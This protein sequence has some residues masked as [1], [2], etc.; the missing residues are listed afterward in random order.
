[1]I[2]LHVQIVN[3]I[4]E[5]VR[6]RNLE[7]LKRIIEN[8]SDLFEIDDTGQ[9]PLYC[10]FKN[11]LFANY[12]Q[13]IRDIPTFNPSMEALEQIMLSPPP[14]QLGWL[15][16]SLQSL[17]SLGTSEEELV[18]AR[19]AEIHKK[20]IACDDDALVYF[21]CISDVDIRLLVEIDKQGRFGNALHSLIQSWGDNKGKPYFEEIKQ[22]IIS[23]LRAIPDAKATNLLQRALSTDYYGCKPLELGIRYHALKGQPID[24]LIDVIPD[25]ESY[26]NKYG[27]SLF[28][29]AIKSRES[30]D[31]IEFLFQHAGFSLI[32]FLPQKTSAQ[33]WNLFY[34]AVLWQDHGA[35]DLL[36]RYAAVPL[37]LQQY[38][39]QSASQ[40]TSKNPAS[41]LHNKYNLRS[42]ETMRLRY[43]DDLSRGL[44][45]KQY[46]LISAIENNAKNNFS[47]IMQDYLA[48]IDVPL[49]LEDNHWIKPIHLAAAKS[50]SKFFVEIIK[51]LRIRYK[52]GEEGAEVEKFQAA[53]NAKDSWGRTVLEI[54][55]DKPALINYINDL[56]S[57]PGNT[58]YDTTFQIAMPVPPTFL[59]KAGNALKEVVRMPRVEI[60]NAIQNCNAEY[61]KTIRPD[62]ICYLAEGSN[63]FHT[64]ISHWNAIKTNENFASLKSEILGKLR[65]K[66]L[67]SQALSARQ[68]D[69]TP[70]EL[71]IDLNNHEAAEW[72]L[73]LPEFT[74]Q[75]FDGKNA[76]D[77][78]PFHQVAI[79]GNAEIIRSVLKKF[80]EEVE[81]L[82]TTP[83]LKKEKIAVQA[84]NPRAIQVHTKAASFL[85][86]GDF[87]GWT[88]LDFAV[89]H[90]QE[91]VVDILLEHGAN[92]SREV[93]QEGMKKR[94][95]EI[96]PS[97]SIFSF[98]S[99]PNYLQQKEQELVQAIN[100]SKN[101]FAEIFEILKKVPAF[102]TIP[103]LS[104][105]EK[106]KTALHHA[107]KNLA[108]FLKI[109]N[110]IDPSELAADLAID[111]NG[112]VQG[113]LNER[114]RAA[115]N[116]RDANGNTPATLVVAYQKEQKELVL[117]QQVEQKAFE[118]LRRGSLALPK[119]DSQNTTISN[120][121]D[122]SD[123]FNVSSLFSVAEELEF[124]S[125]CKKAN[126]SSSSKFKEINLSSSSSVPRGFGQFSRQQTPALSLFADDE[127]EW[128]IN[129]KKQT[130][131]VLPHKKSNHEIVQHTILETLIPEPI[132]VALVSKATSREL[133]LDPADKPRDDGL[134]GGEIASRRSDQGVSPLKARGDKLRATDPTSVLIVLSNP[135]Q[136]SLIR[137]T[138]NFCRTQR[139]LTLDLADKPRNDGFVGAGALNVALMSEAT[140][141][142][143]SLEAAG[144][145]QD[146]GMVGGEIVLSHMPEVT[147]AKITEPD[148]G[149]EEGR[150]TPSVNDN[151]SANQTASNVLPEVK[152]L[153]SSTPPPP[154]SPP[155]MMRRGSSDST[156]V[157]NENVEKNEIK[158]EI[159]PASMSEAKSGKV[160][161]GF[162]KV[163]KETKK[164]IP[165]EQQQ[166]LLIES[167][168][169]A[170]T[171]NQGERDKALPPSLLVTFTRPNFFA[172]KGQKKESQPVK[173]QTFQPPI[174][175]PVSTDN[176]RLV[177]KKYEDFFNELSK[178]KALEKM[179]EIKTILESAVI[180]LQEQSKQKGLAFDLK[181][182]DH[183]I[184]LAEFEK[185]S[186]VIKKSEKIP[187]LFL[188]ISCFFP[189]LNLSVI[190]K[191]LSRL[192]SLQEIKNQIDVEKKSLYDWKPD[193]AK[194]VVT[195]NMQKSYQEPWSKKISSIIPSFFF[196]EKSETKPSQE[197]VKQKKPEN[198]PTEVLFTQ[199]FGDLLP[200]DYLS[201]KK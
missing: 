112:N 41:P 24:W 201:L 93:T 65:A 69:K 198:I 176:S 140:S 114:Q 83:C 68:N 162:V 98:N 179:P 200:D 152:N 31:F 89:Y 160:N 95:D 71:A 195:L 5:A 42:I 184:I 171:K 55:S 87:Y 128:G 72:L 50:N 178:D 143:L 10:E 32:D 145:Q 132:N 123:L 156:E 150:K 146:D 57:E 62:E 27:I 192:A 63:A 196:S 76:E 133:T 75:L 154:P 52:I 16:Q 139:E 60:D 97:Q 51:Q 99:Q 188:F 8:A 23:K 43:D 163:E 85:K 4:Q 22:L 79:K 173:K 105:N 149:E 88:A 185:V 61:F 170:K 66:K 116:T 144:K 159:I 104:E 126:P 115:L 164:I 117:A 197:N 138:Y 53:L 181:E 91:L 172:Q 141:R 136:S 191:E 78:T 131:A 38:V 182:N 190:S 157:K 165:A 14:A 20:I 166:E 125:V 148:S 2:S 158:Q 30:V 135:E 25:K 161:L 121:Y 96:T 90:N 92:P 17:Q 15:Q 119:V 175:L 40:P 19:I 147:P 37:Q 199:D 59:E 174:V 18:Q 34:L 45:Y 124:S 155:L 193:L 21:K 11:P 130:H 56:L 26:F 153:F 6:A 86:D 77:F 180:S 127:E 58:H 33:A 187:K 151:E 73:S 82:I 67:L 36:L 177:L 109:L 74:F 118:D 107:A 7:E 183:L 3:S 84:N 168:K 48:L 129:V 167:T 1:M 120:P 101:N 111:D 29:N 137:P 169:L 100:N 94:T 194:D 64:L 49:P 110:Q 9:T 12:I 47:E 13:T 186:E 81:A 46:F 103:L 122:L 102:L 142:E 54:A 106:G 70:L 28:S 39:S 134:V 35:I 108:L 80:P 189:I 113:L 44:Y